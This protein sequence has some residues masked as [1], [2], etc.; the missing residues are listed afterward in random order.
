MVQLLHLNMAVTGH[1]CMHFRNPSA[2]LDGDVPLPCLGGYG[3]PVDPDVIL[4]GFTGKQVHTCTLLC[5]LF[6]STSACTHNQ[7]FG[8]L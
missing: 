7:R 3:G 2:P 6:Y 5:E 4:G 8:I 1:W